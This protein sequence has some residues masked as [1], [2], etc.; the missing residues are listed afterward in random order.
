MSADQKAKSPGGAELNANTKINTASI[1]QDCPDRKRLANLKAQLA[2][3]G[4]AVHEVISGGY[5]VSRWNLTKFCAALQ[6]LESFAAQ[7]GARA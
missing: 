7:V 6:D 3:K 4:F 2:L 5:F 1:P